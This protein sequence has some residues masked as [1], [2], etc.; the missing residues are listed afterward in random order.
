[1]ENHQYES[2]VDS[3]QNKNQ[4]I[5]EIR[6][7][8][9]KYWSLVNDCLKFP[10]AGK[11]EKVRDKSDIYYNYTLDKKEDLVFFQL[12]IDH[13]NVIEADK[14]ERQIFKSQINLDIAKKIL[15]PF[16][17]LFLKSNIFHNDDDER[18][19]KVTS[20][21][22]SITIDDH[23]FELIWDYLTSRTED[24]VTTELLYFLKSLRRL[25]AVRSIENFQNEVEL[26]LALVQDPDSKIEY[27]FSNNNTKN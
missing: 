22:I 21:N 14:P 15:T 20:K 9:G 24:F 11:I 18:Y 27:L 19:L 13:T 1:M 17:D 5:N 3:D 8:L 2:K 12:R 26:F 7:N 6:V 16:E 23:F 25:H 4:I 10:S